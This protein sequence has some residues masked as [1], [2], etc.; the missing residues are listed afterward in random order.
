[1][2]N[3]PFVTDPIRTAI[4]LAYRNAA[5]VA[6]QV[7]PRAVV[8]ARE[9]KY[10][11]YNKEDRFTIPDTTVGRKGRVNEV[12]FGGTEAASMVADYGLEDPIPQEDLDAAAN[13]GFDVVGNSTELLSDL[14]MLDR[15]KRVATLVHTKGNY[16]HSATLSGT[17]QWSHVDSDPIDKISTVL[18]I[19]IMRPNTLV[20]NGAVAL[21]L[22]KNPNVI[23]AYNGTTGDKG[24][25]PLQFLEELLELEIIVG[26]SRYNSANKG[27]TMTLSYLWGKH[28][29]LI[30][31]N[32]TATPRRGLT[33]GLTAEHG[34]RVAGS[35]QDP[36]IGLRGGTRHRV[37]ESVK[38]LI[39]AN[40]VAYFLENATA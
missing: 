12:E 35:Q 9:F 39:V 27:Q 19:P 17:D 26:R 38:E 11:K 21:A 14:L 13:T 37:G 2:S 36:N 18:E 30:Y 33:F 29:A 8:G 31:K 22:R 25:V 16:A 20:C 4:A 1:M 5:F 40:D 15:E 23:K 10:T 6:D 24:M 28:A 32:S 3:A 34:S 7:L